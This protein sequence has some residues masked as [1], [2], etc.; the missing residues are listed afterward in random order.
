MKKLILGLMLACSL[1]AR[2]PVALANSDVQCSWIQTGIDPLTYAPTFE[3]WCTHDYSQLQA[4]GQAI[5]AAF[6]IV[7][8]WAGCITIDDPESYV[9][10]DTC[11]TMGDGIDGVNGNFMRCVQQV[12]DETGTRFGGYCVECTDN[13]AG[14]SC[15]APP[16]A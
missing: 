3:W 9:H 6:G 2:S 8:H 5:L 4:M 11:Q 16:G 15:A 13:A 7:P 14:I 12:D 10:T 1:S